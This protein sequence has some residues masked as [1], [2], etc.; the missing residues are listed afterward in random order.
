MRVPVGSSCGRERDGSGVGGEAERWC[1]G[2]G[3]EGRVQVVVG[4][5]VR[6]GLASPCERRYACLP[7]CLLVRLFVGGYEIYWVGLFVRCSVAVG[8][9]T[10]VTPPGS[11]RPHSYS[12]TPGHP[13][14]PGC[15]AQGIWSWRG[16]SR[17]EWGLRA[18]RSVPRACT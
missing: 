6:R 18:A 8:A 5:S 16:C 14:E 17:E 13:A 11:P 3:A 15:M 4:R 2:G 7:V 10:N 9:A 1:A 12:G